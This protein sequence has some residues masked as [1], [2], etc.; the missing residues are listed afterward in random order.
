MANCMSDMSC[1]SPVM[2]RKGRSLRQLDL[3]I[4]KDSAW[5]SLQPNTGNRSQIL[6]RPERPLFVGCWNSKRFRQGSGL[7]SVENYRGF[8]RAITGVLG[9]TVQVRD[10]GGKWAF[11]IRLGDCICYH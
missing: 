4:C 1:T 9:V 3:A 10:Q 8:Q 11:G 7:G 6:S 5:D 2:Q